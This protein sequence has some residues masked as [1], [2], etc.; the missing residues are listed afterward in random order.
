[1][2][3]LKSVGVGDYI[4]TLENYGRSIRLHRVVRLT[5]TQ[6]ICK[7]SHG[8][9]KFRISNGCSVGS[10][11]QGVGNNYAYEVTEEIRDKYLIQKL[12]QRIKGLADEEIAIDKAN[13]TEI[14]EAIQT[15]RKSCVKK[16]G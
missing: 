6:V 8:E 12:K 16:E 13:Y 2:S 9:Y 15:I 11:A 3:E 1:M 7:A 10:H 4:Y 5:V 14:F